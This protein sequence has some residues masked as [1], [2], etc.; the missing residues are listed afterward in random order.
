MCRIEG[1]G[2]AI[3]PGNIT[4]HTKGAALVVAGTCNNNH[5]FKV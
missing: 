3:D 4:T 2:A 5:D 1:C